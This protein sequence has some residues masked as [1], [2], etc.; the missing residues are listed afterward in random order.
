MDFR[1]NSVLVIRDPHRYVKMPANPE[2]YSG[3]FQTLKGLLQV[4]G[5]VVIPPQESDN[6]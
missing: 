6:V 4:D 5:S 1:Q 3:A 2:N